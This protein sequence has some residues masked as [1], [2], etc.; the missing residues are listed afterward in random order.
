MWTYMMAPPLSPPLTDGQAYADEEAVLDVE[1][2]D[3]ARRHEQLQALERGDAPHGDCV[4]GVEERARRGLRHRE[5]RGSRGEE[6][7]L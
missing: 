3:G 6:E 2:H 4:L 1:P 5:G 7:A